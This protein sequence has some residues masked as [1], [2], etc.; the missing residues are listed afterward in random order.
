MVYSSTINTVKNKSDI[1][2]SNVFNDSDFVI[3]TEAWS[4]KGDGDL[5]LWD[6]GF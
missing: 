6:D 5:F 2:L 3:F 4:D 1:F